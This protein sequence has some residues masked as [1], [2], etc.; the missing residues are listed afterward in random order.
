MA[1]WNIQRRVEA[2]LGQCFQSDEGAVSLEEGG[3]SRAGG[4]EGG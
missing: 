1:R 3:A 2:A 4:S